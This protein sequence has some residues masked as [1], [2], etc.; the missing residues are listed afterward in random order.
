[1][2]ENFWKQPNALFKAK[3]RVDLGYQPIET[4]GGKYL[5]H[6]PERIGL[7][8]P[9][10]NA[11]HRWPAWLAAFARQ[12]A[13]PLHA[14]VI[15]SS[16]QDATVAL[17]KNDGIDVHIIPKAEFN[18]GATRQL[19][20]EMLADTEIIVYLTQDAILA[21]PYAIQRLISSF[22]DETVGAAYGRQLPR[23]DAGRIG[24]FARLFNYPEKSRTKSLADTPELGIKT[25]F[26]SNSFAAYRR[27]ALLETG[28]FPQ[29]TIMSEDTCV[30]ARMLLAG[31]KVA[32]NAEA[33]VYHSHDYGFWEEFRRYFDTGVF[34]AREP[35]IRERFG[36]AETEGK[37]YV[38]S[39]LA[40]L[41]REA[42]WLIPSATL[43]TL[44]KFFGY[45][46]GILEAHLPKMLKQSFS[47]NKNYWK[48]RPR[49]LQ[50][51]HT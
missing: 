12:A 39:E 29:N 5:V 47:M 45:R 19:A 8:V 33:L 43:R 22:S 9:T 51:K 44:L 46:L 50:G 31:W 21:D 4:H 11:G 23:K 1:M 7:V 28:G 34:H 13:K 48:E 14:L 18:H 27:S 16:S 38:I 3:C 10:L 37:R 35:W 17:T 40:Y 6:Q 24:S 32:Y 49:V 30:A 2:G 25:A 15:D 36:I 42:P 41:L 26:I 20:A